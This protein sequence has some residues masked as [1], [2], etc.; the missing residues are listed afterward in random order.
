MLLNELNEVE[1]SSLKGIGEVC[2]GSNQ[3]CPAPEGA[4]DFDGLAVSLKRH[5]DTKPE[6]FSSVQ[7]K[8]GC[9]EITTE[10]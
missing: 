7:K 3:E 2:K 8:A 5:P 1:T 10:S 9:V 6:F 4:S